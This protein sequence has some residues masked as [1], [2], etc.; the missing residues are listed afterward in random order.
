MITGAKSQ[1]VPGVPENSYVAAQIPPTRRDERGAEK[2]WCLVCIMHTLFVCGVTLLS[3]PPSSTRDAS[4]PSARCLHYVRNAAARR[5]H[6]FSFFVFGSVN[7]FTSVLHFSSLKIAAEEQRGG[8][9]GGR[10]QRE[11]P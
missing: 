3:S 6:P 11:P 4:V 8:G 9:D 1:R 2:G 5:Q 10:E 7:I